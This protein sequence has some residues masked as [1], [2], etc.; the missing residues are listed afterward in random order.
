ML[1]QDELASN[2]TKPAIKTISRQEH[3]AFFQKLLG[4]VDEPTMPFGL[5]EVG[6]GEAEEARLDVDPALSERMKTTTHR[7]GVSVASLCHLAWALVLAKVAGKDD[8]VFGTVL[9]GALEGSPDVE[10]A[11]TP[12]VNSLPMRLEIND[13]GVAACLL[14]THALLMD[15]SLHHSASLFLAK[16]CSA[17]SDTTPLF[18]A[19]LRY[20]KQHKD[21]SQPDFFESRDQGSHTYPFTLSID[22]RSDHLTVAVRVPASIGPMRVCRFVHTALVSLVEAL[23]TEPFTPL[24]SLTVLPEIERQRVLYGWNDT[25]A[26][27]PAD[28]CIQELFEE[29]VR[30]RPD[31]VAVVF[32]DKRLSYAELNRRANR[33]AH[34]LR[35]LGVRPDVRVAI[36]VER[37]FDMIVAVLAVL[38][39]GGAYV[40]LDPAYPEERLRFMLRDSTPVA[41]LTQSHFDPLFSALDLHLPLL[42]LDTPVVAW[43]DSPDGDLDRRSLGLSP[44]HLA[45]VI[46]TSGSTGVPKGV[47]VEHR[48]LCNL[49][50]A[51]IRDFAVQP[52][53][54]VLQFA[55]FSFDACV[56]E[57]MMTLCQGAALYFAP[58]TDILAG[59]F[60]ERVVN[61]YGITHATLPPAV[62]AGMPE[63]AALRSMT[64][65]VLAGEALSD[66][67]ASRWAPGRRLIN[68]YGPTESTVCATVYPYQAGRT[69][70]PPIGRPIAN[71]Q[72][73]ILDR[74]K[75]PVPAGVVGEIYIGGVGV[76]RGY[77]NRAELTGER[78]LSDP[79]ASDPAARM[80]RTGDLGRWLEDGNIEFLGR[81][82]FQIKIRGFRIELGE[83]EARLAEHPG[84]REA[85]VIARDDTPGERRLVAYYTRKTRDDLPANSVDAEGL[86]NYMSTKLPKY[87]TPA[88]YVRLESIPLT[89]NGKL[90]RAA[91]P[92]PVG[93]AFGTHCH[94][95]PVGDVENALATIWVE[96]LKLEPIGRRDSFF[97]L[98]GHSLLAARMIARVRAD[99]GVRIALFSF[100]QTP[101]IEYLAKL[102]SGSPIAPMAVVHSGSPGVTPLV[103]VAPEPW[104][105]NLTPYLSQDQ[106]VLSFV[107]SSEELASTAPKHRLEDLA[108]C[109]VQ[110]IRENLPSPAYVL[111][112]F[113]HTS[114]LAYECAQ[115]LRKLGCE[116]PLLVMGDAF[117]PGYAQ[118]LSF[119]QRSRRRLDREAFW[120]SAFRNASLSQWSKLL[121]QR[122][123]GLR[124]IREQ[125]SWEKFHRS[126]EKSK[127]RAEELYEALIVAYLSY[128]PA[129]Y[130]GKVLY[131]QSGERPQSDLWNPAAS[132]QGV[133]DEL[134]VF[135]APGDHTSIFREPHVRVTAERLQ[136]AL[137]RLVT[138][139]KTELSAS[140]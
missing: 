137:D 31:A 74:H 68:A 80:Y 34:Y 117:L 102:V 103:W 126:S 72:L 65:M 124:A 132:W 43:S 95:L 28:H 16:R 81:N 60:L 114:L 136:H 108:A 70:A 121:T 26:E 27:F 33:L 62:L 2:E 133:M 69:G 59:E 113:C 98:G 101:T 89:V 10:Q 39:A 90:N 83:I 129:P 86:R 140:R 91:L 47:L 30:M 17:V 71:T 97:A 41:V 105:P 131:L 78:F 55:S 87:M 106:P 112:G 24:R 3:Q 99:F 94:E 100:I 1:S 42:H 111:S 56:S 110:K 122:M 93:E 13:Q 109:M 40:P 120:L 128:E 79:F 23:E 52:N 76:A 130:N 38:K 11:G 135:E 29:Q 119:V 21:Q 9:Y 35:E 73:Y 61:Q 64:T 115:Q 46:Y 58:Q 85:V 37:G 51:Q 127:K 57:I 14:S 84:I 18:A 5:L 6:N 67:V 36:C 8:V 75:E 22:E 25:R 104:Q 96:F 54:R 20:R 44:R 107:L 49:A 19:Q 139:D 125:R 92:A 88:A 138:E 123:G 63:E 15:L 48:G 45:Y 116:I 12:F 4:D 77:L 50:V 66:A 118:R 134:E 82:D 53:S 32:E 7:L